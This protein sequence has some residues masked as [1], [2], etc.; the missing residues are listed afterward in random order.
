MSTYKRINTYELPNEIRK[1][2][3]LVNE[4]NKYFSVAHIIYSTNTG[5]EDIDF[6]PVLPDELDLFSDI[7][8]EISIIVLS[9]ILL[10]RRSWRETP[11]MYLFPNFIYRS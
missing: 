10:T 7:P 1:K 4:G 11:K 9:L 8:A 5:E 6:S 2:N 3:T